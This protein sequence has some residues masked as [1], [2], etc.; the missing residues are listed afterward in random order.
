MPAGNGSNGNSIAAWCRSWWQAIVFVAALLI[1]WGVA[2]ATLDAR[3]DITS[4]ACN[5]NRKQI[6]ALVPEVND[7]SED[8]REVKTDVRWIRESM[9]RDN[10][11]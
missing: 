1:G 10:G 3:V 8:I 7:L 11:R 9:E 2:W 6:E 4:D 5:D